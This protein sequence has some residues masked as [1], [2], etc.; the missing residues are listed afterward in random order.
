MP[1]KSLTQQALEWLRANPGRTPYAA[2]KAVGV[3]PSTVT[4][5][6]KAARAREFAKP[7]KDRVC[8]CCGRAFLF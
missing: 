7:P 1:D 6:I 4:R 2:A 5:A 8:P 3:V